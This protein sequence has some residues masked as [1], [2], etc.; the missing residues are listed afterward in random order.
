MQYKRIS[1][2]CHLDLPWLPPELFVSE[3]KR[4]L[5]ERMPYVED[6]PDGPIGSPRPGSIWDSSA[7]SAR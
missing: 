4:E 6:G 5:R 7:V 2:D 3:A 1:A